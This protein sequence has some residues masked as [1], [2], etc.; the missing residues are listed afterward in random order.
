V[1]TKEADRG[2]VPVLVFATTVVGVISS[3]GA[4]LL[5]TIAREMQVPLSTAQW[6]LTITVL[7]GAVCTPLMGRMADGRRRR[8]TLM[9]GLAAVAVGCIIAALAPNLLTLIIGRALQGFGLG[10]VPLTMAAARDHLPRERAYATIALLSVSVAAGVGV[11][12]PVGG[13]LVQ[14]FGLSAAFTFGAAASC[15]ALVWVV[16]A[17][18]RNTSRSNVPLDFLGAILMTCGLAML[19]LGIAE[20][21]TWGWSSPAV[22]GLLA[23]GIVVLGVWAFQQLR[24]ESPLVD[25]RQLRHPNVRAADGCAAVLGVALYMY[26]SVVTGF[27][28]APGAEGYGFSATVAV[29]GLTL[30]PLSIT[31][32]AVSRTIPWTTRIVGER[33][34]LPLG[35]LVVAVAG[36]FFAVTHSSLWQAFVMMAVVGV[37]IGLTSAVIPG[38]IVRSVPEQETGSALGFYQVARWVGYSVGSAMTG[39]ILAGY[40]SANQHLPTLGGY[41]V[42][43]WVATAICIAAAAIAW[44]LPSKSLHQA[45]QDDAFA[46]ESGE[47]GPIGLVALPEDAS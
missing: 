29:S 5:P 4:P 47:L 2:L 42:V 23:G 38:L 3:L 34:L 11:G 30:V 10:I 17:V 31:S 1:R 39:L 24:T 9:F 26:L 40:T 36:A 18:P 6:S 14:V 13:L 35:S 32:I 46:V 21:N 12:Y 43:L 41:Q 33:A 22:L 25:L 45:K 19:L 27:V 16:M 37:G 28:Q 15:I 20:G 7:A 8:E 44:A